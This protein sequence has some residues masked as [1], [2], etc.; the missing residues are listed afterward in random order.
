MNSN[1]KQQ[2]TSHHFHRKKF[3]LSSKTCKGGLPK[4]DVIYRIPVKQDMKAMTTKMESSVFFLISTDVRLNDAAKN[5]NV[6][7][8]H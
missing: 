8:T 5:T 2:R 6:N 3:G 1:T 7:L 4:V